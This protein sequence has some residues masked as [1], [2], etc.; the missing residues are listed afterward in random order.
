MIEPSTIPR[1]ASLASRVLLECQGVSHNFGAKQV[2]Y[3]INLR[4]LRGQIVAMVGPSGSGKSTLLR[5]LAGV[6][7]VADLVRAGFR[8]LGK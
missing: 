2:L 4:V 6:L 8:P 3:D 7:E 1:S 5:G